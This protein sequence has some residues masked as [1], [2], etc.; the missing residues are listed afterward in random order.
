MAIDQTGLSSRDTSVRSDSP[1]LQGRGKGWGLSAARNE[2]IARFAH[3]MRRNPTEP[4]KRLWR[5]LSNSQLGGYKFR[6]QAPIGPFIAD[7]LCPRKALIVEV[8]GETHDIDADRSRDAALHRMGYRVVHVTNPDVMD[9][10]DGVL[11]AILC[12]LRQHLTMGPPPTP[13]PPLKG[14]GLEDDHAPN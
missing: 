7:F 11:T 13:T 2:D 12:A 3:A 9:N 5:A 6:R 1:P 4:E 8:D 10:I 14:R